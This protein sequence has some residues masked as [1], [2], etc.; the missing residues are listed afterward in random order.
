MFFFC[1]TFPVYYLG[2]AK[3]CVFFLHSAFTLITCYHFIKLNKFFYKCRQRTFQSSKFKKMVI[4]IAREFC[5]FYFVCLSA[6]YREKALDRIKWNEVKS[7]SRVCQEKKNRNGLRLVCLC[8]LNWNTKTWNEND[9]GIQA[10]FLLLPNEKAKWNWIKRKWTH[11]KMLFI[12]K[13]SS[14]SLSLS[15]SYIFY[16]CRLLPLT[17]SISI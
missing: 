15:L 12:R 1:F 14:F 10:H 6:I 16:S 3:F 8:I 5:V 11:L 7:N 9:Y 13:L 2:F 4:W 17:K